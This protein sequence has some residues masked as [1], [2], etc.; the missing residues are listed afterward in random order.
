MARDV[1]V[2]FGH[3]QLI[4]TFTMQPEEEHKESEFFYLDPSMAPAPRRRPASAASSSG[5]AASGS[6]IRM[7]GDT[8]S[9]LGLEGRQPQWKSGKMKPSDPQKPMGRVEGVRPPLEFKRAPSTERSRSKS[10]MG[11]NR[12]SSRHPHHLSNS[13]SARSIRHRT[14]GVELDASARRDVERGA[15]ISPHKDDLN[16]TRKYVRALDEELRSNA[17]AA[18]KAEARAAQV[19]ESARSMG[20]SRPREWNDDLMLGVH[21]RAVGME[22]KWH[23][24]LDRIGGLYEPEAINTTSTSILQRSIGVNA[25]QLYDPQTTEA[26][27]V[28]RSTVLHSPRSSLES[29]NVRYA[30]A[31]EEQKDSMPD[32]NVDLGF[33][34]SGTR[35]HE[36][37]LGGKQLLKTQVWPR[38]PVSVAHGRHT[39]I[40]G[41]AQ[42]S[43]ATT[44]GRSVEEATGVNTSTTSA[45]IRAQESGQLNSDQ[46]AS[47][48]RPHGVGAQAAPHQY[49]SPSKGG[50]FDLQAALTSTPNSL[51][52]PV[53]SSPR[54]K[55]SASAANVSHT[56]GGHGS[57]SQMAPAGANQSGAGHQS[58]QGYH[59]NNGN[60]SA[61]VQ[62]NNS[63]TAASAQSQRE[64]LAKFDQQTGVLRAH[65]R[66][67]ADE[68]LRSQGINVSSGQG[69]IDDG[70]TQ[71]RSFSTGEVLQAPLHSSQGI[72]GNGG[73]LDLAPALQARR[74]KPWKYGG[75]KTTRRDDRKMKTAVDI[76]LQEAKK[77]RLPSDAHPKSAT[78]AHRSGHEV[79]GGP[80][81]LLSSTSLKPSIH[82]NQSGRHIVGK[83]RLTQRVDLTNEDWKYLKRKEKQARARAYSDSRRGPQDPRPHNTS[84][85]EEAMAMEKAARREREL[86][87]REREWRQ[88]QIWL[89]EKKKG[90]DMLAAKKAA[91]HKKLPKR[92][93]SAIRARSAEKDRVSAAAGG[94]ARP[95]NAHLIAPEQYG[96]MARIP[97]DIDAEAHVAGR[98]ALG[99]R[100]AMLAE[101]GKRDTQASSTEVS[102][103]DWASS[104]RH[105]L[106]DATQVAGNP[107]ENSEQQRQEDEMAQAD[108]DSE[109]I[110]DIHRRSNRQLDRDA[111]DQEELATYLAERSRVDDLADAQAARESAALR[112]SIIR[113]S[114]SDAEVARSRAREMEQNERARSEELLMQE[115]Q[116]RAETDARDRRAGIPIGQQSV[117]LSFTSSP[118]EATS[119]TETY[120]RRDPESFGASSLTIAQSY[121]RRLKELTAFLRQRHPYMSDAER[122][123]R[124][125]ERARRMVEEELQRMDAP[126]EPERVGWFSEYQTTS[127]YSPTTEDEAS[128]DR[129][130]A[131]L[132]H[133]RQKAD[134]ANERFERMHAQAT[135]QQAHHFR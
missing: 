73:I 127:S 20:R 111:M 76:G 71:E 74:Q 55:A 22:K 100:Q 87:A 92:P 60:T 79:A 118:K 120:Q 2:L 24:P 12:P 132:E 15:F 23:E 69:G 82:L 114:L 58:Q 124:A 50:R 80:G 44:A 29:S 45:R 86:V 63:V 108:E 51:Q 35:R 10:P 94:A 8:T 36:E 109:D 88:Q 5:R 64:H 34:A 18:A 28:N 113:K 85:I 67:Y 26:D 46:S 98:D 66:S 83:T 102:N 31:S 78:H 126:A 129:H 115:R 57:P 25:S 72:E 117:N 77:R 43:V 122:N 81:F 49:S 41:H 105:H 30:R 107:L 134:R 103:L 106:A 99:Q 121:D 37:A 125:K 42:S 6:P 56:S 59:S 4:P 38:D 89:H 19:D 27:M 90:M 47:Y 16:R 52:P 75:S 61:A 54:Q 1:N 13:L 91:S 101:Q 135:E 123:M 7:E 21:V 32:K 11:R 93:A 65:P 62:L 68:F 119:A 131:E 17:A 48:G 40:T 39:D 84:V 116:R 9:Q 96:A 33:Y 128:A 112:A 3:A 133:M 14:A 70:V 97:H 130:A 110:G 95:W 53:A 104:T